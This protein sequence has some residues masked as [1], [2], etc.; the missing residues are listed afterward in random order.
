MRLRASRKELDA[1][2]R[3]L[4]A[5][6][7]ALTAMFAR[8]AGLSSGQRVNAERLPV[9]H[10]FPRWIRVPSVLSIVLV[11]SL[12]AGMSC[13]F[14]LA[15]PSPCLAIRHRP[16]GMTISCRGSLSQHVVSVRP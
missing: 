12:L 3:W 10:H 13:L 4:E 9:V 15:R 8:F 7:P 11:L 5:N 16:P 1:M 14:A 6:D 2:E